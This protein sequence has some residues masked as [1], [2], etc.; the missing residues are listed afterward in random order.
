MDQQAEDKKIEAPVSELKKVIEELTG[1]EKSSR[2]PIYIA[3]MAAFLALVS[4][5]DDEQDKAAL[6]AQIEASNKFSYFQAKNIRGTSAEIA[7]AN[8][9]ANG[10]NAE[11]AKW[12]QTADRY[13]QEKDDILKDAR[14]E[15][16]KRSLALKQGDYYGVAVA[17]LQ[18]AI[19]MASISLITG[20]GLLLG[21]SFT[22]CLVA[23]LFTANGYGL[24]FDIPTDPE[25]IMEMIKSKSPES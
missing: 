18:I 17:L 21:F 1:R 11:A 20:G 16:A 6:E 4:M 15:Q 8:F 19:V 23:A 24:Y 2:T 22:L 9:R 14:A 25:V 3:F 12:Q 13:E 10:N 7:A 5:A